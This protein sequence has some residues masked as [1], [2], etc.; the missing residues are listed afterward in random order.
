MKGKMKKVIS[1][2]LSVYIVLSCCGIGVYAADSGITC[3]AVVDGR[4]VQITGQLPNVS[5]PKQVSLLVGDLEHILYV[6]QVTSGNNGSFAFQFSMPDNLFAGQ[7]PYKIGN[8]AGLPLYEGVLSYAGQKVKTKFVDAD[9]TVSING[10]VPGVAG[11]LSCIP[12]TT[13]TFRIVNVTDQTEIA[14]DSI[15]AADDVYHLSYTL[16]SLLKPKTYTVEVTCTDGARNLAVMNV[17]IASSTVLVSLSG[18]AAMA[19]G[20][21]MD[22]RLQSVNTGLIDKSATVTGSKTIN[23]TLPNIISGASYHLTAQGYEDRVSAPPNP[24]VTEAVYEVTGT[25]NQEVKVIAKGTNITTFAD[26]TFTLEYN[27]EQL[28]AASLFGIYRE[29]TL[30]PGQKGKVNIQTY[31]PGKIVFSIS[32][33]IIPAGKVWTGMLNVFKF[34]FAPNYS[35]TAALTL[36]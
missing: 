35:G 4:S 3:T 5:A 9:V 24:E 23:T 21:S 1:T 29:D 10:Y 7:Y 27:P 2:I 15:T 28:Q 36:K 31:E 20:V 11:T 17:E 30:E 22:A 34:R 8:D 25:A 26:R 12:G 18:T 32:D 33:S 14:H 6:D 16:P 13:V 19:D